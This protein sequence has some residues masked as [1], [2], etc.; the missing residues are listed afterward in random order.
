MTNEFP[1]LWYALAVHA[2]QEKAAAKAVEQQGFKVFLPMR[3]ERHLW[4]DRVKNVEM[5][6]FP[7]YLFI[8]TQMNPSQRVRLFKSASRCRSCRPII[9]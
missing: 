7:G 6:F 5:A 9:G 4:S 2:R 8:Y 3:A 1:S